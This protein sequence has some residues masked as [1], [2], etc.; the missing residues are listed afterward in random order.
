V[1]LGK[2]KAISIASSLDAGLLGIARSNIYQIIQVANNP[3][4]PSLTEVAERVQLTRPVTFVTHSAYGAFGALNRLRDLVELDTT[5]LQILR[6]AGYVGSSG[7]I[8]AAFLADYALDTNRAGITLFSM[9]KKE[10]LEFNLRRL[11]EMPEK[12]RMQEL[13]KALVA[14]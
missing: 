3:F 11:E 2:A 10:H 9:L 5:R 14:T 7:E 12:A 1:H 4:E 13:A 6:E 8:A